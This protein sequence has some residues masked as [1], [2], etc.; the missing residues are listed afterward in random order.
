MLHRHCC[1]LGSLVRN[2]APRLLL[3]RR[4]LALLLLPNRIP[5]LL[6]LE[7]LIVDP[8]EPLAAASA[9]VSLQLSGRLLLVRR[10]QL[11]EHVHEPIGG[12]TQALAD[13]AELARDP[14]ED[15]RVVAQ[16]PADAA[17]LVPQKI[18]QGALDAVDDVRAALLAEGQLGLGLAG[19]EELLA[20]LLLLLAAGFLQ[21]TVRRR[22]ESAPGRARVGRQVRG[23]RAAAEALAGGFAVGLGAAGAGDQEDELADVA[24][25]G[26]GAVEEAV[27]V[28]AAALEL[29]VAALETGL[30]DVLALAAAP[31][32]GGGRNSTTRGGG[33]TLS[34]GAGRRLAGLS[35]HGRSHCSGSGENGER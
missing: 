6:R 5:S 27:G 21:G 11:P 14:V 1:D 33:L 23:L 12:L 22:I 18:A 28:G 8:A 20:R 16:G 25:L 19:G 4:V 31:L 26:A 30:L 15:L 34:G 32:G 10:D 29:D 7:G 24:D 35:G 13:G 2:L 3:G 9:D 17:V